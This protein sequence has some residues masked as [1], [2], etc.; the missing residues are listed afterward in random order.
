M[1]HHNKYA[2]AMSE[3]TVKELIRII[4]T[5][6]HNYVPEAIAAAEDE[7]KKRN[8]SVDDK[9]KAIKNNAFKA[10]LD[11]RTAKKKAEQPLDM[12]GK[13]YIFLFPLDGLLSFE[14]GYTRKQ[15]EL[16]Y[17]RCFGITFYSLV[18]LILAYFK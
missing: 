11:K 1:I 5:D 12:A 6:I 9:K 16:M 7:L 17:W 13:I 8:L 2:A 4:K 18:I 14:E 3:K 15:E 10:F